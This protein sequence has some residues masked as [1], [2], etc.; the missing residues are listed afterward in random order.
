MSETIS[1]V[2]KVLAEVLPGLGVPDDISSDADMVQELGLDSLQAI[3]FL[4]R[5]E[6]EFDIELDYDNLNL[7]H[8]R[9]VREFSALVDAQPVP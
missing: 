3:N 7:D 6:D 2:K 5:I 8:L 9:S 1:R 4:L